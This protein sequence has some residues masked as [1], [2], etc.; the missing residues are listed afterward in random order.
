MVNTLYVVLHHA[1]SFLEA[2]TVCCWTHELD[3][4]PLGLSEDHEM[5]L[6]FT[7][8][9]GYSELHT[10]AFSNFLQI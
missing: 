10:L 4:C 3:R 5:L 1:Q 6:I 7:E 9:Q 2:D 8:K